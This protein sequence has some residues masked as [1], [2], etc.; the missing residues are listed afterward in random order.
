MRSILFFFLLI[1]SVA[2]HSQHGPRAGL[3]LATQSVGSLFQ[4]SS[5]LLAGPLAGWHFE[6]PVH[7][8]VSIMPEILFI[9][10]GFSYRTPALSIRGRNTYRYIEVPVLAKIS[11]DKAPDGVYLLA[12]PTVGYFLTGQSKRWQQNDLIYDQRF[13]LPANGRRVEFS[14]LVG[15]GV[16]GPKWAFDIRAQT[17][18][19][20]FERFTRIQNVVYS[21]TVAYRLRAKPIEQEDEEEEN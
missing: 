1:A 15:M 11:I 14:G 13:T 4:N 12:G 17:S 7:Q 6:I 2:S 18:V 20:P 9:T 5:N 16:E 21:I 10:K 8:Q 19:T 3:A